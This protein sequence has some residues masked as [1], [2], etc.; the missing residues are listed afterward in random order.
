MTNSPPHAASISF[1]SNFSYNADS[2]FIAER[3]CL[4]PF[5]GKGCLLYHVSS[6]DYWVAALS[7]VPHEPLRQ[8]TETKIDTSKA[9]QYSNLRLDIMRFSF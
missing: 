3:S 4:N 5:N 1:S 2:G 6:C 9:E 7:D 8:S